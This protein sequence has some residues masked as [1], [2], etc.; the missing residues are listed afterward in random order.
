MV[1]LILA[2]SAIA[3]LNPPLSYVEDFHTTTYKDPAVT[4]AIWDTA[5][6]RLSLSPFLPMGLGIRNAVGYGTGVAVCGSVAFVTTGSAGLM[7]LDVSDPEKP[8]LMAQQ[9]VDGAAR[10]VALAGSTALVAAEEGGLLL[11]DVTDPSAPNPLKRI[12]ASDDVMD[13]FVAGRHAFLAVM[14][15]GLEIYDISRPASPV[16]VSSVPLLDRALGV[17]VSGTC[18][19]VS[20]YRAGVAVV[21]VHDVAAPI[22]VTHLS[23]ESP[24]LA[25]AVDGDLLA[26]AAGTG[27]VLLFDAS[28]ALSPVPAG[29]I[30]CEGLAQDVAFRNRTLLTG[31]SGPQL[32]AHDVG[33]PA[34]PLKKWSIQPNS[35]VNGLVTSGDL[36]LLA[37]DMA[38]LEIVRISEVV[39]APLDVGSYYTMSINAPRDVA[40]A[41]DVACLVTEPTGLVT[42]TLPSGDSPLIMGSCPTPGNAVGVA[43]SGDLACVAD[44]L[45]GLRLFDVSDPTLPVALGGYNTPGQAVAVAVAGDM[46]AVADGTGGLRLFNL[47]NT[48]APALLGTCSLPGSANGVALHGNLACVTDGGLRLVDISSPA[49]PVLLGSYTNFNGGQAQ[50]VA[51]CGTVAWVAAGQ[52]GMFALDIRNPSVPQLIAVIPTLQTYYS[53]RDPD[54]FGSRLVFLEAGGSTTASLCRV[55]DVTD[56][57]N[58][59]LVARHPLDT[60]DVNAQVVAD[61][62]LVTAVGR[63][64][65]MGSAQFHRLAQY[66]VTGPV[67]GY[68]QSLNLVPDRPYIVCA[69]LD[70]TVEGRVEWKLQCNGSWRPA[71]PGGGWIP[72]LAGDQ[73]LKWW[74]YLEWDFSNPTVSRVQVDWRLREARIDSIA[75]VRGDQGGWVNV[76]LTGSGLDMFSRTITGYNVYR[77]ID[78]KALIT[79]VLAAKAAGIPSDGTVAGVFRTGREIVLGGETYLVGGAEKDVPPGVWS[80]VGSFWPT[81]SD[82]YIVTVPTVVDD[83]LEGPAWT[84]CYVLAWE[85]STNSFYA[86][87]P[88][89]GRS[90]DNIAPGVPAGLGVTYSAA[91]AALTWSPAPEQDFQYFRVY[92]GSWPGFEPDPT[93]LVGATAGTAWTDPT[94]APWSFSYKLTCID[95][96]GNESDPASPLQVS[97]VEESPV[98]EAFALRPCAPNPFN[99][100]TIIRWDVPSGGGRVTLAIYDARG[101]RVRLL[102]DGVQPAGR[103]SLRWDGRDDGGRALAA[104]VYFCRMVAPSSTQTV[105]MSL[106]Q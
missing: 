91:G 15:A 96:A 69:R 52:A 90:V 64:G 25:A 26:V 23:T 39:S 78:D 95:H 68:G 55:Y 86:S 29:S 37:T 7:I 33:D 75:D 88:D 12:D 94:A 5:A 13:V 58:P 103:H 70:A 71:G 101:A 9:V 98:P 8:G 97:G 82:N 63:S 102:T 2:V 89:S 40:V 67:S 79:E 49:G 54:F 32:V 42:I 14:G 60:Y 27:G 17:V 50:G 93:T 80:V 28:D 30:A 73:D 57:A 38:E 76:Y 56:P 48:A 19:Y 24:A 3:G 61:D 31:T 18:A 100:A 20:D 66:D 59:V 47:K 10:A 53:Y 43:I 16:F 87:M 41:G 83:T 77:R 105:K 85:S 72:V 46:A 92:R 74:S 106:V 65:Y 35:A 84:T 34:D 62:L 22:L 1:A 36:A 45:A 104:G 11:L 99:A 44:S 6:G 4:T 51:V 81:R 21:D